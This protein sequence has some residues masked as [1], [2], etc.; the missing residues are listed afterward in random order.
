LLPDPQKASYYNESNA[1]PAVQVEMVKGLFFTV[2]VGVYSKPVN[3]GQIFNISP[4]NSEQT[5]NGQIRY[6]SGMY[7]SVELAQTQKQFVVNAGVSDA[8]ITA[9]FN[10]NRITVAQARV[11]LQTEGET[12]LAGAPKEKVVNP[13]ENQTQPA[14]QV[15]VP[16]IET[17]VVVIPPVESVSPVNPLLADIRFVVDLGVFGDGMPQEVADAI[18]Q[19]PEAGIKRVQMKDGKMHYLSE[20]TVSYGS[21]DALVFELEAIGVLGAEIKAMARGQEIDLAKARQ[22]TGQ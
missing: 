10:G 8:F 4:L 19:L 17:E 9:Y 2:Q 1:A 22:I 7:P 5:A 18:L 12:I 21:A 6:T 3:A 11:L 14:E 15:P 16:T 13:A 20:P